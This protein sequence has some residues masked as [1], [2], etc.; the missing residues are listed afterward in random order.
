MTKPADLASRVASDLADAG[1]DLLVEHD[2]ERILVSGIVM[3]EEQRAAAIDIATTDVGSE[4]AVDDSIEVS[5]AVPDDLGDLDLS[6]TDVAGFR[7]STPG[8]E[9]SESAHAGDFT[10]QD[11]VSAQQFAQPGSLSDDGNPLGE[12]VSRRA[13]RGEAYVPPTDPVGTD[14]EVIGGFSRS[15][16]DTS[17]PARSSDGTIG[18]EAIRDA[19]ER[20]LREDAATTALEIQIEVVSGVAILT[21]NVADMV[22]AENAEAVAGRVTGVL[23]VR[24]R[25]DVDGMDRNAGDSRR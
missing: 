14:T 11:T 21:G 19:I 5:G 7:G 2:E 17:E 3:T 4:L 10:D 1:L 16:M 22:D 25:L 9:D 6:E 18:D 8:L 23:E 24:E 13:E 15:S 20:E 12:E